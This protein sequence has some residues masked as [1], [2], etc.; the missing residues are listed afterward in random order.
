MSLEAGNIAAAKGD[1]TAARAAWTHAA[2]LAPGTP[3]G[4]AA[5]VEFTRDGKLK[6]PEGYRKW[7]TAL[8]QAVEQSA[9]VKSLAGR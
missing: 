4:K 6:K 1:I 2:Q 3:E 8:T 9:G 5:L 7:G